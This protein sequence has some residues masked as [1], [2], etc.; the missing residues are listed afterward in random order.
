M[1]CRSP[2][3]NCRCSRAWTST[4]RAEASSRCSVPTAPE[5]L[6]MIAELRHV[7]DTGKVA[8]D[9]LERFGLADAAGRRVS[10]YSGGMRRRLDIALSLLGNAPVIFLGVP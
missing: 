8:D 2:T 3:R 9:L 6:V 10:T 7:K 5:N 4:W 1:D